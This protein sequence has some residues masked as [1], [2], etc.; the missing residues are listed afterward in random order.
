MNKKSLIICAIS[1]ISL[2]IILAVG[3][4]AYLRSTATQSTTN[5]ITSLN[6][7]ELSI[8]RESS[9]IDND[10][11]LKL[12]NAYPVPDEEGL[13]TTPYVFTVTNECSNAV[14]IDLNLETLNTSTLARNNIKTSVNQ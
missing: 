3:S 10:Y 13:T 1:V 8:D 2:I 9:L 14:A 12:T 7:L 4:Y 11:T 6:C 5:T